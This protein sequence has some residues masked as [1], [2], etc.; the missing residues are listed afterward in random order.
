MGVRSRFPIPLTRFPSMSLLK[1]ARALSILALWLGPVS[2]GLAQDFDGDGRGDLAAG[3]PDE[4]LDELLECGTVSVLYGNGARQN[5]IAV[6][7]EWNA[8]PEAH[9]RFGVAL[10]WGDF[11]ADGFDDLAVGASQASV[12]GL[13]G[14]GT[15][16]VFY[17]SENGLLT[18]EPTV[19]TQSTP[20]VDGVTIAEAYDGFGWSL[21]SGDFDGDQ[22]DDLAVGAPFE[23]TFGTEAVGCVSVIFGSEGWGLSGDGATTLL[24]GFQDLS[25]FQET[26]DFF[27]YSLAAGDLSGDGTDD[28][29]IGT[30][31]EDIGEVEDAGLVQVVPFE[32]RAANFEHQQHWYEGWNGL[33]GQPTSRSHFG[34]S[35]ATGDFDF[36]GLNEPDGAEDLAIGVPEADPEGVHD[37]GCVHVLF[38]RPW[39][40]LSADLS[41]IFH[42]GM[43]SAWGE[44]LE[45]GDSFGY[46]L[47]APERWTGTHNLAIGVPCEDFQGVYNAGVVHLLGRTPDGFWTQPEV[48]MSTTLD[49]SA[50]IAS[51]VE[52]GSRFG[53]T[54]SAYGVPYAGEY[55]AELVYDNGFL[56]IGAPFNNA[57]SAQ[58]EAGLVV[59]GWLHEVHFWRS[60]SNQAHFDPLEFTEAGDRFGLTL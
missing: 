35:L 8:G 46:A 11:D 28:L 18:H 32:G 21:A 19:L 20:G 43:N 50:G 23:D 10:A 4:D 7:S 56:A 52:P 2:V 41:W 36:P 39:E 33:G 14:A 38:G 15:V 47:A 1:R 30:P 13:S 53:Y 37:A 25:D 57:V 40:G 58:D 27:G 60:L 26:W 6:E 55:P 54:L 51:P 45:P 3:A 34:F 5:V 29:V 44:Q 12:L 16:S 49:L 17:G 48:L 24:Q 42:Q 9:G 22:V 59:H 31:Y